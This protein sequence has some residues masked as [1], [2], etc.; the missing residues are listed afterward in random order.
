MRWPPFIKSIDSYGAFALQRC[1]IEAIAGAMMRQVRFS[2]LTG[3][4]YQ[5]IGFIASLSW[6][7]PV[8]LGFLQA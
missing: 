5:Y 1:T 6:P 3:N 4:E 2:A 8:V 7:L